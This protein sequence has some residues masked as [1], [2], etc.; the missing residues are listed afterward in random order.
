MRAGTKP[1]TADPNLA[2]D[3]RLLQAL[4]G[5]RKE[6]LRCRCGRRQLP[7]AQRSPAC[8]AASHPCVAA[9]TQPELPPTLHTPCVLP[10]LL[11]LLLLFAA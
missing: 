5:A 4:C 6:M 3:R 11:L 2:R 7:S 8:M 1:L 10:L 9:S